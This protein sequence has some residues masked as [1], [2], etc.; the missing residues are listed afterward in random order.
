MKTIE[1]AQSCMCPKLSRISNKTLLLV[2]VPCQTTACMLWNA[3]KTLQIEYT[4]DK[5]IPPI[6]SGWDY[7]R[8]LTYGFYKGQAA[9]YRYVDLSKGSCGLNLEYLEIDVSQ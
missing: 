4:S 8:T 6:G 2:K 5:A 1:E 7:K 3:D 9:W